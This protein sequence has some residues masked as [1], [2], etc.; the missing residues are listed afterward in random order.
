MERPG[1]R[2][3]S[4]GFQGVNGLRYTSSKR[5]KNILLAVFTTKIRMLGYF[6]YFKQNG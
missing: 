3:R 2:R 1:A 5:E 4:A 6:N